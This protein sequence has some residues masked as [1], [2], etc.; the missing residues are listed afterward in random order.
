MS[1]PGDLNLKFTVASPI[2]CGTGTYLNVLRVRRL[3]PSD[4]LRFALK[5]ST[6]HDYISTNM[7]R[8]VRCLTLLRGHA[9]IVE[10]IDIGLFDGRAAL[11]LELMTSDLHCFLQSGNLER[12]ARV[13]KVSSDL[14]NDLIVHTTRLHHALTPVAAHHGSGGGGSRL[15]PR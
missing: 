8:E 4:P 10:L 7:L 6:S 3:D 13:A 12:N 5:L 15:L 9:H 14:Y 2:N 1:A 11:V